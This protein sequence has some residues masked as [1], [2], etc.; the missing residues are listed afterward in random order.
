MISK[1]SGASPSA[2]GAASSMTSTGTGDASKNGRLSSPVLGFLAVWRRV[3]ATTGTGSADCQFASGGTPPRFAA[4]QLP[5]A[6]GSWLAPARTYT[7]LV[8]RF[9]GRTIPVYAGM[10]GRGRNWRGS[11]FGM[12]RSSTATACAGFPQKPSSRRKPGS[13]RRFRPLESVRW[14]D[15]GGSGGQQQFRQFRG[16]AGFSCQ[17]HQDGQIGRAHV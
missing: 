13:M 16:L 14:I 11:G 4:T 15:G 5:S 1:S 6:S 17:R 12:P 9:H 7:V 8:A 3:C 10:T 2:S